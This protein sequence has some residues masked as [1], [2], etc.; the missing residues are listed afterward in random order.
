[1]N[2]LSSDKMGRCI[3]R[4]HASRVTDTCQNRSKSQGVW[5]GYD[6]LSCGIGACAYNM[7][8]DVVE[9]QVCV[10]QKAQVARLR[11]VCDELVQGQC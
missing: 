4:G 3:S 7:Q 5:M 9:M 8:P 2:V 10:G 1:M 11:S 6:G